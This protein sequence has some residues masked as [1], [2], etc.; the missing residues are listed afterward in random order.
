VYVPI[1]NGVIAF[2]ADGAQLWRADLGGTPAPL[3]IS[4]V[5]T[6]YAATDSTLFAIAPGGAIAWST[7]SIGS[8]TPTGSVFVAGDGTIY[9]P[10]VDSSPNGYTFG[11]AALDPAGNVLGA[12]TGGGVPVV[13]AADGTVYAE[14]PG[15]FYAGSYPTLSALR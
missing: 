12:G 4:T 6:V 14:G 2:S 9:V 7:S 13:M 11:T 1:L 15:F 8:A 5:G 3:A 10:I